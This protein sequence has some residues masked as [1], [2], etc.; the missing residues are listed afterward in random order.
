M[1]SIIEHGSPQSLCYIEF[2]MDQKQMEALRERKK[3]MSV[4]PELEGS[5]LGV[6]PDNVF[7]FTYSP[8]N[9]STPLFTKRPFQSFEIHKLTEGIVQ[10][11]G[12]VAPE[13]A[14]KIKEGSAQIEFNL[15]PEPH[16]EATELV[17]VP[18]DRVL[19]IKPSSRIDGNY[20]PIALDAVS[21]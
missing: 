10:I 7:G 6:L 12:F 9:E 20:L 18:M 21:A 3:L 8:V 13:E 5:P 14:A 1:G 2:R 4:G 19:R 17:E 11:L 16:K 15:Y